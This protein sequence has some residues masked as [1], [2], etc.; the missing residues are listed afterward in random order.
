LK[1]SLLPIVVAS[2]LVLGGTQLVYAD[3][4]VIEEIIVTGSYI[5]KKSQ[6]D[7]ASPITNIDRASID[8]TGIVTTQELFRWIPSNTGS[9]NQADALTQGGTPG[10]ANV[11]LRGLGLG[12][13]LV[14]INNRRQTVSS[15]TANG[16]DTF[17]DINSLVPTI[18]LE[19]IEI[20][21]DGAA[22]IYGS[23]A[24]AGVVNF[25]TRDTFE[26]MEFRA[27]YQATTQSDDLSDSEFSILW[28]GGNDQTHIVA[29]LSYFDREGL[30]LGERDLPTQTESTFGNP[31]S[32]L[33]L[34]PSPTIPT[35]VP[36]VFNADPA[37][38]TATGSRVVPTGGG[39]SLCF[40]EFGPSF[41]LVPDE[42]R[43]QAYAVVNHS[44]SD[45][46]NFRSEF[47]WSKNEIAGGFSPSFPLL[48]FPVIGADHPGNPF[49]VTVAGRFR[50]IGD[51]FGEPGENRVVNT[52]DH[53]TKKI[54][55]NLSGLLGSSGK[56]DYD[57][58][59]TFS[60]NT[61]STTGNDQ[62]GSRLFLALQGFGGFNCDPLT[63]AA[64]VGSCGYYN[65]FGSALTASPGDATFN[66]LEMLEYINSQNASRTET[67][68]VTWDAVVT[69]DLFEMGGG[70]AGIAIGIQRREESRKADLS[71]DANRSD[72]VFL[73]GDADSSADR[74]IDAFFVEMFLPVFDNDAGSLEAQLAIRYEDY[75][76]GF[77]STD[78]KIGLLYRTPEEKVSLRFTYG[79]SF[80]APTLFQQFVTSTA[81]NPTQDPL[82]GSLVFLGQT[83]SANPDLAPE[84]ADTFNLGITINP[85][86]NLVISLDYYNVQY[87]NRIVSQS[88]QALIVAEAAALA[89][90]G[91]GPAML[92]TPACAPLTNPQILR[93]PGT[94]TPLR[95]FVDRFNAASAETDG[96]DIEASYSWETDIGSFAILNNT[97]IVNSFDI[98]V[99]AGGPTIDGAG[100]R[101][102]DSI[103]ASSIPEIRSNTM[104]AWNR[105][106]MG[107]NIIMRY[108]DEYEDTADSIDAWWVF[109]AQF[110]YSFNFFDDQEAT[111]TLGALNLTDEEPPGVAGNT[112]EFGYDPKV[113]DPRGRLWYVRLVYAI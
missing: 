37:C 97:T 68:L 17:T 46:I 83:A 26:G 74:E 96:F 59:Y 76:T 39:S 65:P 81:L 33:L 52:A 23:D 18:M 8:D 106:N 11:N 77:D 36:G 9:E 14:L 111:V 80:R 108:I 30:F 73:I 98:Q 54:S 2:A 45:Y 102:E 12:S 19:N 82:T 27:N 1:Y 21:K 35:A 75:D 6:G 42:K 40:F 93:D 56:W 104:F 63:G 49:G 20:L 64:G 7:S 88:G 100:R 41:S 94:G 101:N 95:I 43:V 4:G 87:E 44:V 72:L 32:Y 16:G 84:E 34:G 25:K 29:A 28:G 113:H 90:A 57:I 109:D 99:D 107:A 103:L 15:A 47:G 31:G 85:I 69:G 70:T 58:A 22:A 53:D 55:L 89:A 3:E 61:F 86:D 10:T 92:Q 71:D 112:N 78:P 105:D 48:A 38:G 60:E 79:T 66:S 5:K 91:C 24:V 110:N 51:G 13:T 67:D 50:A 62:A